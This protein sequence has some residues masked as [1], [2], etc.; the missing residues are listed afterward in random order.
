MTMHM[1]HVAL[2]VT[3]PDAVGQLL[4]RA[5]GLHET[6]R[7]TH[8]ITLSANA[9]HHEV[10]LIGGDQP[11][12]DHVGLEVDTAEELAHVKERVR[13]SGAPLL[14]DFAGE[15]GIA[16]AFRVQAPAD[17]VIEVLTGMERAPGRVGDRLAGHARKFGHVTLQSPDRLALIAFLT[18]VLGF[19]V[20]DAVLD[21]TWMRC[22]SDH[23]GLAVGGASDI[24]L[25]HHYAFE[26]AG[27]SGMIRYLDDLALSGKAP[28]WGP[29][30]HGPGYNLFTYLPDLDGAL[31]EGY[32]DL[33]TVDGPTRA[34]RVAWEERADPMGL[35]GGSMPEGFLDFGIP[36]LSA[37]KPAAV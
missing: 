16:E 36:I 18:S 35:W 34:P 37:A 23:H 19:R 4:I 8:E 32:A 20:S 5:L 6:G 9:K 10:Q 22:D 33:E 29:G 13:A 2:R 3:D 24:N 15:I 17:L 7:S 26:L 28:V 27:W 30:R 1:S 31:I 14:G 12:L 25:M 21:M 11:G